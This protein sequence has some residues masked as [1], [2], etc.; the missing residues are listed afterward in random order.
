MLSNFSF[1][2]GDN[3]RR[4]NG[5]SVRGDVDEVIDTNSGEDTVLTVSGDVLR[6]ACA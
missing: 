5:V 2:S 4:S 6:G 1:S 3:A